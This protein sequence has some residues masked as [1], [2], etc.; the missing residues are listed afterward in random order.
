MDFNLLHDDLSSFPPEVFVTFG[1]TMLRD[2]PADNERLERTRRVDLSLGG[3]EFAVAV[4]L[5]R[6]GIPSSYI[7]RLPDNPY[8]WLL[9][10]MARE[11]GVNSDH[12]VWADRTELFGRYLYELGRTPRPGAVWYQRKHSAAS[13]MGAGMVNW[14]KALRNARLLHATGITFGLAAHSGYPNN[15]LLEAFQEA[16]AAKPA[17]CLV[18]LDFNYRATLWRAEQCK[19]VMTPLITDHVDILVT[20]LGD[21]SRFYG[22]HCGPGGAKT[23]RSDKLSAPRLEDDDLRAFLR[24]VIDRFHLKVVAVPLRQPDSLEAQRWESAA[25]TAEGAYFR[26]PALRPMTLWDSLGGGDAWVG[27]FYYGLLTEQ[28]A[29]GSFRAAALPKGVLIGDAATRLKHTLM[30][31][32]PILTRQDIQSLLDADPSGG[33]TR[34]AR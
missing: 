33:S 31:D 1:E 27:G 9:R 7:T 21:M 32:L 20:T 17:S 3:S 18:G 30:Y 4:M 2:T 19:A 29:D 14:G 26:S 16:L 34:V 22:L 11:Q 24:Q 15:P 5:A 10:N 12:F 13:Q 23:G 25:M 8:G 6:L 28:E